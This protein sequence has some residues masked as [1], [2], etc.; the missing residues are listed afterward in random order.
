[1]LSVIKFS[2]ENEHFDSTS[3]FLDD[4][5]TVEIGQGQNSGL[6]CILNLCQQ[7]AIVKSRD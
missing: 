4:G 5:L 1:M 6:V 7:A 2:M 3:F